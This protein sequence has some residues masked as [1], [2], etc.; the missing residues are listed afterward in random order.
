MSFFTDTRSHPWTRGKKPTGHTLYE[1]VKSSAPLVYLLLMQAGNRSRGLP[2]KWKVSVL[3]MSVLKMS[4]LKISELK[5]SVDDVI[6]V[7]VGVYNGDMW[8]SANG[9][10]LVRGHRR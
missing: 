8:L 3:K 9:L 4:V 10:L 6:V 1:R 2:H 5:I 7:V